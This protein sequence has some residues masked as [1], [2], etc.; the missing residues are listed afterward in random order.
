MPEFSK[1]DH[2]RDE[3]R[4]FALS[5]AGAAAGKEFHRSEEARYNE[6]GQPNLSRAHG[7]IATSYS[8][9]GIRSDRNDLAAAK[10]KH[11]GL[12]KAYKDL[13]K[14]EKAGG[15]KKSKPERFI[16]EGPATKQDIARVLNNAASRGGATQAQVDYLASLIHKS[17]SAE[18]DY[19]GWL[20]DSNAILSKSDATNLIDHYSKTKGNDGALAFDLSARHKDEFGHLH[21]A[22]T[23]ISK[24]VV[25]PYYGREIPGSEAL[26]LDPNRIYQ[27]FRAP[28]ELA[29]AA[30]TFNNIRLLSEHAGVSAADPKED[31][32]AGSTGTDAAFNDPFLTNSLV[33]WRQEDIDNVEAQEK[34]ELSCSYAYDPDMTP[35]EYKG[36]RYDGVMR[37]IR[38]NHVALVKEGRAGP[39]VMVHDSKE[40]SAMPLQSRKAVLA[41]GALAAFLKPKLMA[42]TVLA[43]DSALGSVNRLNWQTEK[44][45]VMAIVKRMAT[46][47]LAAD[48][49]LDGLKLAMDALDDEDADAMDEMD[50]DDKAEDEDDDEDDKKV[51]AAK[52][53][54]AKDKAKDVDLKEWAKEE[55]EEPEHKKADDMKAMD[56]AIAKATNELRAGMIAVQVAREDVRPIIGSVPMAMDSAPDIY[57]LALDHLKVDLTGVEKSAYRGLMLAIPK[58]GARPVLAHDS[59]PSGAGLMDKFPQLS[60]IGAA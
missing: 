26:G 19:Q 12:K 51:K 43:L 49:K 31:L 1:S 59:K 14:L 52:D 38:A 9:I 7:S 2:P 54:A 25:N 22:V 44:P 37:N 34:C 11:E 48:A 46:P 58:P 29:A 33:I 8:F 45:K 56:A 32:V 53:K 21:V 13:A 28:E 36:L 42:G 17:P 35:G 55:E 23:N 4:R 30:H 15:V 3:Y 24:A 50:D 40:G 39:D 16:P 18:T 20:L 6:E 41:K 57:K 60:R 5:T 27:M 47:H 10:T